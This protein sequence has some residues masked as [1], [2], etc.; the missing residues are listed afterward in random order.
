MPRRPLDAI[1]RPRSVALVGASRERHSIGWEL[2]HNLLQF[3]FQ[4]Q[5]FPVNPRA[6]VVH[7]LKCYPSVEAI[8]D[9]VDLAIIAVPKH[10]VVAQA[11]ACGRKGVQGLVVITAGF[12]EVGEAGAALEQQLLEV[13]HRF[14]MRMVGP[15]CMGVINTAAD[16]RLQGSFSATTEPLA[17]TIAFSS[18]SGA[19]GEAILA[20]MTQL[21]LGLSMF[22]SLGNKADVSGNDLLGT[23]RTT[24]TRA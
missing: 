10:H 13:V 11:E 21:D 14:G 7:S 24:R 23:G 2:L 5:V 12:K 15:N 17:G 16:V 20:L 9:P 4:G 19:L 6:E 18:Q 8:P 22:V 3:E 1:F